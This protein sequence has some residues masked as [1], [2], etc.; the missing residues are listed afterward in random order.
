MD[1]GGPSGNT[2]AGVAAVVTAFFGGLATLVT[3]WMSRR[4]GRR[5][6]TAEEVAAAILRAQAREAAGEPDRRSAQTKTRTRR[7]ADDRAE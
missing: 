7:R 6:P 2:L 5:S 3:A 4:N 1:S